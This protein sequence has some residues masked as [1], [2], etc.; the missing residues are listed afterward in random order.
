MKK[1]EVLDKNSKKYV[2]AI[3]IVDDTDLIK[4]PDM[5]LIQ[6][7]SEA[8]VIIEAGLRNEKLVLIL[9]N[10]GEIV[11]PEMVIIEDVNDFESMKYQAIKKIKSQFVEIYDVASVYDMVTLSLLQ[12]ELTVKGYFIT[13]KNRTS[14]TID[15]LNDDNSKEIMD[16]FNKYLGL[17]DKTNHIYNK[18]LEYEKTVQSILDCDNVESLK[19]LMDK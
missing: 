14:R 11:I 2:I 10:H 8:L 1:V 4:D 7:S 13:E 9:K 19:T 18:Y 5:K 3:K 15:V 6:A 17:M 16:I 12:A